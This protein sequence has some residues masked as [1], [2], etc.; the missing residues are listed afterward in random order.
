MMRPAMT[1]TVRQGDIVRGYRL[2]RLIAE[3]G[4]GAVWAATHTTLGRRAAVK[5]LAP[6]LSANREYVSRFLSEARIVNDF[7]HPNI[8]DIFDFVEMESPHRVACIMELLE[9]P[10]LAEVIKQGKLS[11]AKSMQITLQ[12]V[13]AL[14]QVHAAGVVHRDLK[15]QNIIIV[16]PLDADFTNTCAAKILDFGIAK[17]GGV[18]TEHKTATGAIM[19]TPAYM[20]PEQVAAADVSAA[21]DLYAL[22]EMLA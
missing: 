10:T 5:L 6:S 17:Q 8:V 11:A 9:G 16:A 18:Q 1:G 12:I 3:G 14:E 20:A 22:A 15:P 21:T 2:D 4:M 13:G 19:G 7:R